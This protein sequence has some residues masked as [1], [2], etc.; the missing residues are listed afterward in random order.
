MFL[1]LTRRNGDFRPRGSLNAYLTTCVVNRARDHYR[2]QGRQRARL[3]QLPATDAE[4]AS[5]E[6]RIVGSEQAR[7]LTAAV[8]TLPAEQREVVVLHL[9]AGLR[10]TAIVDIQG[11]SANTVRGRYRYALGKLRSHL[12]E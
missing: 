12:G 5:P 8:A 4:Q 2:T 1:V 7:R 3:G 9:K 6:E 11:V 10:F